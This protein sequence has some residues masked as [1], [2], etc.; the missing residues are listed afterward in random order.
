M[1]QTAVVMD[2]ESG[3]V[4]Y[5]YG[6]IKVLN[7]VG[8]YD[9][10]TGY[11]IVGVPDGM[12]AYLVDD[13]TVRVVFQSESYG[14]VAQQESYP[15]IVN[16]TGATFTGSH[17]QYVDYDRS[18]LA[19][20]F[21]AGAPE[22]AAPMVLGSG[23]LIQ[24]AYNLHGDLIMP[25]P[26]TG[27]SEAPHFSN[28]DADGCGIWTEIMDSERPANGVDWLMQ[29]LCS[30]HLEEKHQW[31][32]GLGVEDDL[33][34]TN[35]EW[36]NFVDGANFTGI[37]AHAID[38]AN[39]KAYAVGVFTLGGFEKIVEINCGHP[40]Y[41]CFSPSGYNGDFG[42]QSPI[43]PGTRPDGTPYVF[44]TNI[45]PTRLYIGKKGYNASGEP[46][47]DFLSRNGL[48][49]GQLYGFATKPMGMTRDEYHR[50]AFNGDMVEGAFY[51]IDWRWDG[52]VKPFVEDGCWAFQHLTGPDGTWEFWTAGTRDSSGAKTEHN[53]PDPTGNP[54]YIQGSTAGY[55]G[56]YDFDGVTDLLNEL[57]ASGEFPSAIPANYTVL[58]GE[59][60]V[61][62][63]V[64]LGGKG[65]Y[66]HGGNATMNY[67]RAQ[68]A[69][70]GKATFEDV[71]GMEWYAAAD[72][73]YGYLLIQ[74]DS[75][76]D[77]GE[78]TFIAEIK[79]GVPMTYYFIAMSGGSESSRLG[80]G[81]VGVPAGTWNV[82]GSHEFSG[83]MDLSGMLAKDERGDFIASAGN[84]A[85]KRAAEKMV[86]I[87]DKIIAFGLQAHNL[88]EGVIRTFRGDRGGQVYAYKPML[89]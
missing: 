30:A 11:M 66:R 22:A 45:V 87:N 39:S 1:S 25:R 59:T 35:E 81:G 3:D 80:I 33:F 47:D 49:Y 41:V 64:M 85:S 71:D 44:P 82:P 52:V 77:Y 40:D 19:T 86:P 37:P 16:P 18:M 23:N 34:L 31:G 43:K 83:S 89:P 7:T 74:E 48:A 2:G 55:F 63:Q 75:G 17:V 78:R 38:L 9:A 15:F 50:S 12:G 61:T 68:A 57:G 70:E 46:A 65:M 67:D 21:D 51:P 60:D 36:T 62:P 79:V 72:S 27:C 84:G 4:D 8:E 42:V 73:E 26:Q 88:E 69:G 10:E 24:E 54:R 13:K 29:S 14:P 76:N 28:T 32:P 20:F 6:K 56:I 58:Q 53:T 5:P